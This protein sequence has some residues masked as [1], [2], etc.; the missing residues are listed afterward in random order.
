MNNIYLILFFALSAPSHAAIQASCTSVSS[1]DEATTGCEDNAQFTQAGRK[2]LQ[3]LEDL[4]AAQTKVAA[5][6]LAAANAKVNATNNAQN[7]GLQGARAD[8]AISQQTLANLIASAKEARR[9]VDGYL[10]HI[11]YP[12]DFDAPAEVIGDP[13]KFLDANDC[14][15]DNERALKS[16]LDQ[17]D[18]HIRDLER[19][20]SV[21]MQHGNVSGAR[22]SGLQ[23]SLNKSVSNK[24]SGQGSATAVQGQDTGHGS[25]VTG[26][27]KD[28]KN[29][30]SLSK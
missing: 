11:Y 25:D 24:K 2:C 16:A 5:T 9:N 21:A 8:Y 3:S 23:Q 13:V 12:E 10:N 30:K 14:Y 26:V 29:Q 22:E 7:V 28:L 19:T 20:K 4:I 1:L 6:Q 18:K 15:S 17:I 27:E